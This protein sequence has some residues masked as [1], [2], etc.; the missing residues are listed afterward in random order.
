M[1]TVLDIFRNDAFSHTS[2]Q[3][4]VDNAPFVPQW[5]GDM[6]IFEPKPIDTVEVLIYEKDGGFAIIPITERGAPDVQQLRRQ[7]RL[8]GLKTVRLSKKDTLYAGDLQGFSDTALP[9]NVRLRN[10]ATE[11]ANRTAQLK[12]DMEATKERHRLAALQGKLL[13]ADDSVVF[14]YFDVFGVAE[15]P[16]IDVD[17]T[18]DELGVDEA[19]MFFQEHIY[20]PIRTALEHRWM[21]NTRVGALVGDDYWGKLMRNPAFRELYKL[22]LQGRAIAMEQNPLAAPNNWETVYFGGIYWTNYRGSTGGEIAVAADE[23]T[24]FPMG[25]KDVFNVYWGPGETLNDVN[26][27]GRPEFLYVQPDVRTN[28]ADH[29]DILLRSYPLYACIFPKALMRSRLD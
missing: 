19:M 13:D 27:K 18:A 4:V 5:L 1:E 20:V 21:P 23:A 28:I 22:M 25:A 26:Q 6:A 7:G 12:T 2:L 29:V 14:D 16:S 3:R 11:V 8:F 10:A 15:A 9:E 24:F 17:F